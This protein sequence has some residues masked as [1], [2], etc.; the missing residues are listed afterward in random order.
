MYST[1][2]TK[3]RDLNSLGIFWQHDLKEEGIIEISEDSKQWLD[4]NYPDWE[5]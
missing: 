1:S 2:F 5:N 4:A 3:H